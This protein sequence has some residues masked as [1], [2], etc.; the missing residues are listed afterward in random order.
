[1]DPEACLIRALEALC[2]L[3]R[4]NALEA[5]L[6]LATWI[7]GGGTLPT[8]VPYHVPGHPVTA[9]AGIFQVGS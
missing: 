4:D 1:M 5:L 6:D 8:V 7:R 3:E 2:L 9:T